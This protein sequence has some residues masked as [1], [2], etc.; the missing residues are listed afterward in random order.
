[1]S[2]APLNLK[3]YIGLRVWVYSCRAVVGLLLD[4]AR[5]WPNLLG[6]AVSG[7]IFLKNNFYFLKEK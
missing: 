5:Q 1:V 6:L 4:W 7:P 3:K 2:F